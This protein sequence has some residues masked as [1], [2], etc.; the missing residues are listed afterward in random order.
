MLAEVMLLEGF[1][2]DSKVEPFGDIKRNDVRVVTSDYCA[3]RLL[4]CL[5]KTLKEQ[6]VASLEFRDQDVFVCFD[7]ALTDQTKLRLG[8]QCSLKTI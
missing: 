8:D 6:T 7:S 3:H 2:L 4:V 5:D 1:A